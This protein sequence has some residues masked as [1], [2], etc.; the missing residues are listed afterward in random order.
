MAAFRNLA[1]YD[2]ARP[3]RPWLYRFAIHAAS[4]FRREPRHRRE[5]AGELPDVH[6][7]RSGPDELAG[8]AQARRRL[9]RALDTL[10]LD[11][12]AVVVLHE[13]DGLPI[14]EVATTLGIPLNTA[15]SRLRLAR[16]DLV[17]ALV[18]SPQG[19]TS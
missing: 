7:E 1:A 2:P 8:A 9:H 12:R 18:E 13:I 14:P 11:W 17:K 19:A 10:G 5:V 15:Y 6:D 4:H 3:I 16:A